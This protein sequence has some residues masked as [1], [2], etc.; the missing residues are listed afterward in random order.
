MKAHPHLK[1]FFRFYIPLTRDP[2]TEKTSH[3]CQLS[4]FISEAASPILSSLIEQVKQYLK[5]SIQCFLPPAAHN[6][7]LSTECTGI[8]STCSP[9]RHG[10]KMAVS[11]AIPEMDVD[12]K[13][14]KCNLLILGSRL[15]D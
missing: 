15:A 6:S 14:R 4:G 5:R 11:R 1:I 13:L 7:S 12:Y 10:R 9:G 8:Y 2:G 3:P